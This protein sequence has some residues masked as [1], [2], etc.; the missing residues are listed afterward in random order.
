[1]YVVLVRFR[2]FGES[3]LVGKGCVMAASDLST[4]LAMAERYGWRELFPMECEAFHVF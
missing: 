2:T 4:Y 1:M 3:G